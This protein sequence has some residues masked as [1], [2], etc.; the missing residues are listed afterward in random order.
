MLFV[1]VFTEVN[2]GTLDKGFKG[3]LGKIGKGVNRVH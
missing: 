1:V 3:Q 2:S